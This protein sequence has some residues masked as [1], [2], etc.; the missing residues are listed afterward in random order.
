MSHHYSSGNWLVI[1][2][3]EPE[4]IARWTEFLSWTKQNA[5]GLVSAQLIQDSEDPHHFISYSSWD[6]DE[7]LQRWR[8]MPEFASK[9]GAC[10]VL[11]QDFRGT[12]YRLAAFV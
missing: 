12:N 7:A 3:Q 9:L 4:F 10:R 1:S 5:P 8:S 2:G 11:C 6:S